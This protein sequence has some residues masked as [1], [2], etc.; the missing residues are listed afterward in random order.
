MA[1][2]WFYNSSTSVPQWFS[3]GLVTMMLLQISGG[4]IMAHSGRSVCEIFLNPTVTINLGV[5]W[6]IRA[7]CWCLGGPSQRELPSGPEEAGHQ[8]RDQRVSAVN[9]G[10]GFQLGL[11]RELPLHLPG[12]PQCAQLS[13]G[14]V[15]WTKASYISLLVH[16]K[17]G[18][19][20]KTIVMF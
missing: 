18:I 16:L 17:Q 13:H 14:Q 2:L 4:I 19:Q 20:F 5:F 3:T 9:P 15:S 12:G 8:A 7:L 6:P 11:H 1:L 10:D